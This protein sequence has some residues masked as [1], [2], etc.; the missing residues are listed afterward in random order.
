MIKPKGADVFIEPSWYK[1]GRFDM[2]FRYTEGEWIKSEK[3]LSE[4][5]QAV[6]KAEEAR[7]EKGKIYRRMSNAV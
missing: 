3:S 4:V 1:I 5:E 2:V 6:K 7:E